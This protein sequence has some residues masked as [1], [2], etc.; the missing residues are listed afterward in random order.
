MDQTESD[1]IA[2]RERQLGWG[3]AFPPTMP[4]IDLA[5]DIEFTTTENGRDLDLVRGMDNLGQALSVALTTLRGSNVFNTEFGFDGLNA[6]VEPI[7]PVL[8]RERVRIGVIKVL[9]RDPRVH[10]IVDVNLDDG[11]LDPAG[12]A[13]DVA[14]AA[15]RLSRTLAVQVQ[16]ETVAGDRMTVRLGELP[17]DV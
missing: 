1:R 5:R 13:D 9:D 2:R 10:R 3:L 15:L 8:A 14:R 7:E 12:P 6:L 17:I 11:R 16:F 4:G